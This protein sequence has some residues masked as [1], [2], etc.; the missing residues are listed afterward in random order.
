MKTRLSIALSI[1]L[2][3]TAFS[4]NLNPPKTAQEEFKSCECVIIAEVISKTKVVD[5]EDFIS[6]YSYQLRS[7]DCLKG[8]CPEELTV[9]DENDSGRFDMEKGNQYLLFIK[10][11]KSIDIDNFGF[12]GLV[13]EKQD[14][15]KQLK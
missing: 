15:I 3:S 5:K 9:V 2:I 12:S 6:A 7:I 11:L 13:S 14:L 8:K 4:V 10:N 1:A